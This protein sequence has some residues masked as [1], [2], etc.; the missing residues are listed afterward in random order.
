MDAERHDLHARFYLDGNCFE[1][2]L[3]R[4]WPVDPEL[5]ARV[6]AAMLGELARFEMGEKI[7]LDFPEAWRR[8]IIEVKT[9]RH[10][11]FAGHDWGIDQSEIG[12]PWWDRTEDALGDLSRRCTAAAVSDDQLL[13]ELGAMAANE[14][15]NVIIATCL[16]HNI[17]PDEL[18]DSLREIDNH[19]K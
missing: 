16:K 14:A 3:S 9:E 11:V 12:L 5:A 18:L 10:G 4:F 2:D 8:N 13:A 7:T 6:P 17:T 15:S 19:S 1:P